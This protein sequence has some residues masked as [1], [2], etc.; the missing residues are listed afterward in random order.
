MQRFDLGERFDQ[1]VEFGG[2]EAPGDRG[3]RTLPM[4]LGG[5]HRSE[6]R[7]RQRGF[8]RA[9]VTA[10]DNLDQPVRNQRIE[11]FSNAG[12]QGEDGAAIS[13]PLENGSN[14]GGSNT[15][16]DNIDPDPATI[17]GVYREITYQGKQPN[18][19]P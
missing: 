15:V 12:G 2:A 11:M 13:A 7:A 10:V 14:G 5:A 17:E 1:R 9:R 16:T 8:A 3:L 6:T 18:L 19:R 4:G